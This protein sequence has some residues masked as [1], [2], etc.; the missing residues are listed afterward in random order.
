[1]VKK[2]TDDLGKYY[3]LL[4]VGIFLLWQL[5]GQKPLMTT[6]NVSLYLVGVVAL[7]GANLGMLY[8]GNVIIGSIIGFVVYAFNLY[9]VLGVA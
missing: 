1:M 6:N 2:A 9:V 8:T 4:V 7:L 3:I 5:G